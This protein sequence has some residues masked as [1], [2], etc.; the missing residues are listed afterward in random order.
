MNF[1]LL[2]VADF[3]GWEG[4]G[5]DLP[6]PPPLLNSGKFRGVQLQVINDYPQLRLAYGAGG[7][8]PKSLSV[9]KFVSTN[10]LRDLDRCGGY[11]FQDSHYFKK[12]ILHINSIYLA[13][14]Q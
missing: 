10:L 2:Y 6:P 14:N 1:R 9:H 5:A 7:P 11:Y 13:I 12:K 3:V 4:R 8:F